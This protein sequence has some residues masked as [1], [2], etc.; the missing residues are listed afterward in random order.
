MG[1]VMASA[2]RFSPI[3]T[4]SLHG[5]TSL[6]LKGLIVVVGPNSSGKTTLLREIHSAISGVEKRLLIAQE[7]SYRSLPPVAEFIRH[8]SS[9]NDIAEVAGPGST[10]RFR[11]LGHQYGTQGGIGGDWKKNELEGLYREQENF[12]RNPIREATKSTTYLQ[13]LGLLEV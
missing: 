1:L 5:I 13:Q 11:K 3:E 8:F 6:A 12:V 10:Q 2:F 4:V 7:I 9:T